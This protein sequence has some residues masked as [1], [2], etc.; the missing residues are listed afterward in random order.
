[1]STTKQCNNPTSDLKPNI[2]DVIK[3]TYELVHKNQR[4]NHLTDMI[5]YRINSIFDNY[6]EIG[7]YLKEV[8]Q[9][10]IYEANEYTSVYEY[11][12][13]EFDLSET[14]TKNIISIVKRFCGDHGRLLDQYKEFSFSNLVELLPV[15]DKEIKNFTP[16]MTVKTMRSKKIELEVNKQLEKLTS[17]DSLLTD[18]I[19]KIIDYDW[20]KYLKTKNFFVDYKLNKKK[21]E[22][23]NK[24]DDN[25]DYRYGKYSIHVDFTL[26]NDKKKNIYKF[27]LKIN[28]NEFR[29]KFEGDYY[30]WNTLESLDNLDK[31]LDE[32]IKKIIQHDLHK[33]KEKEVKVKQIYTKFGDTSNDVYT[34]NNSVK[35]IIETL[36]EQYKDYYIKKYFNGFSLFKEAEESKKN[37]AVYI[38]N[39]LDNP[40]SSAV[41]TLTD[42]GEYV[43]EPLFKDLPLVMQSLLNNDNQEETKIKK[44]VPVDEKEYEFR[45]LKHLK[46]MIKLNVIHIEKEKTEMTKEQFIVEYNSLVANID[47]LLKEIEEEK[48]T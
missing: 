1:M 13:K 23:N 6:L 15:D 45:M 9:D 43:T 25:Y 36:K 26:K 16:S 41:S 4:Y 29:F 34:Y 14:T 22:S 10:K 42:T 19:H 35:T 39:D 21:Y 38:F 12:S 48:N 37:Q 2:F 40:I 7:S 46:K 11:A 24:D 33:P 28:L 8:D 17:E 30:I 31:S 18:L 47:Q 20:N 3:P 32:I 44:E 5:N 27:K